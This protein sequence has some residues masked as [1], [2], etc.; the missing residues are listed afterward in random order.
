[1]LITAARLIKDIVFENDLMTIFPSS[2]FECKSLPTLMRVYVDS[3]FAICSDEISLNL[4]N[5]TSMI[6][7][8]VCLQFEFTK[9]SHT[10][11]LSV[12]FSNDECFQGWKNGT[13][14]ISLLHLTFLSCCIIA[15]IWICFF[16]CFNNFWFSRQ[17]LCLWRIR[18]YKK[19][20]FIVIN[21]RNL[22]R[23][24]SFIWSLICLRVW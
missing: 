21:F 20:V 9:L 23:V 1:M 16:K 18:L 3:T 4:N 10:L 6:K 22:Q 13:L 24:Q 5:G 14:R 15:R 12:N 8:F 11:E 19:L 7:S 2:S 17:G